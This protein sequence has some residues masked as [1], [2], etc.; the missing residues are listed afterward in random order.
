MARAALVD[1]SFEQ[2]VIIRQQRRKLRN[3][4]IFSALTGTDDWLN[5][6]CSDGPGKPLVSCPCKVCQV[7]RDSRPNVTTLPNNHSLRLTVP[8]V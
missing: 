1:G 8:A 4:F 7:R 2:V 3:I 5:L 6:V